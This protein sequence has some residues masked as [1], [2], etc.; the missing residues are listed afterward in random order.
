VREH[1]AGQPLHAF[2]YDQLAGKRIIVRRAKAGEKIR[3]IDDSE[4]ELTPE[5]LVIADAEKPVAVAGVMGGKYSEISEKTTRVFLEIARFAPVS[6]RRTALKLGLKSESQRRFEKGVDYYQF[7]A[8]LERATQLL[9]LS[10]AEPVKG[11]W[12]EKTAEPPLKSIELSPERVSVL[13]GRKFTAE[14]C[15][16]ILSLMNCRLEESSRG[17]TVIPPTFRPD[18]NREE[19]LIEEI[20]R[21]SGYNLVPETM[22][23]GRVISGKQSYEESCQETLR[24]LMVGLG[25]WETVTFSLSSPDHFE[26]FNLESENIFKVANPLTEDQSYFRTLIFPS[27]LGVVKR[28]LISGVENPALFEIA[29]IYLPNNGEVENRSRLAMVMSGTKK[30][31]FTLKGVVEELF[32]HLKIENA[33]FA[34]YAHPSFHPGVSAQI[35]KD[36][37]RLGVIGKLHPEIAQRLELKQPVLAAEFDIERLFKATGTVKYQA[38]PRFPGMSRDLAFILKQEITCSEVLKTI[39][40]AGGKFLV[41]TECFDRY[42]GG[43]IAEGCQSMAFHLT[44]QSPEK[45]LTDTEVQQAVEQIVLAA[46]ERLEAELRG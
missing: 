7:P 32:R 43:Q 41:G 37:I 23:R 13:V 4:V 18:L 1:Q 25:F 30:D 34:A 16:K 6:I 15:R 10:G 31:F 21:I 8:V 35:V 9:A 33:E 42:Q 36:G 11:I 14:E 45:T 19:D 38:L 12:E 26:R 22:P 20:V 17:F 27:L 44:F 29:G 40:A 24:D 46:K 3:T 39:A 2:D 28:N 5:M